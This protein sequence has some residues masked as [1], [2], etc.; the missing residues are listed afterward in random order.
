LKIS[1]VQ[2]H[3][4]FKFSLFLTDERSKRIHN[5]KNSTIFLDTPFDSQKFFSLSPPQDFVVLT[6]TEIMAIPPGL[7]EHHICLALTTTKKTKKRLDSPQTCDI[8][9]MSPKGLIASP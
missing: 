4:L 5:L 2:K 1:F 8:A 7:S 9:S 6:G 3:N